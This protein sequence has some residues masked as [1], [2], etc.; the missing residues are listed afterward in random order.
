MAPKDPRN[1]SPAGIRKAGVS[2]T[3]LRLA[4][5]PCPT[6]CAPAPHVAHFLNKMSKFTTYPTSSTLLCAPGPHVHHVAHLTNTCVHAPQIH[7]EHN[8]TCTCAP[9][10]ESHEQVRPWVPH[11]P[12]GAHYCP[13]GPMWLTCCTMR[14][15]EPSR[16]THHVLDFGNVSSMHT[17]LHHTPPT[18]TVAYTA[19]SAG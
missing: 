14:A 3:A 10:G 5:I 1:P 15:H 2:S 12:P 18:H 7:H 8:F 9:C 13:M 4:A 19:H 17:V 11:T 6:S 16:I